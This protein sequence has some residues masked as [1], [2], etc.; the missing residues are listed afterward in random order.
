MLMWRKVIVAFVSILLFSLFLMNVATLFL[1]IILFFCYQLSDCL[2]N[3]LF[4]LSLIIKIN[5]FKL[6]KNTFVF[7]LIIYS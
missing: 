2:C 6:I 7:I 4:F 5:V 3:I 1:F